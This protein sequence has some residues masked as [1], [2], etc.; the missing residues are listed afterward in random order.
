LSPRV[1]RLS[2]QKDRI[3]DGKTLCY[4]IDNCNWVPNRGHFQDSDS[5]GLGDACDTSGCH[6]SCLVGCVPHVFN[7][8]AVP[9]NSTLACTAIR[10]GRLWFRNDR[11]C[12]EGYE[13]IPGRTFGCQA[14][15]PASNLRRERR[16]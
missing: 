9:R 10:R 7:G 5:D 12:T 2:E 8:V 14:V 11:H 13:T 1:C 4:G 15:P 16:T 6:E 3:K